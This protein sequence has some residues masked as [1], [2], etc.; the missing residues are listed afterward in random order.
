MA[1]QLSPVSSRLN[2]KG[3]GP[4]GVGE[5][6]GRVLLIAMQD[7][8]PIAAPEPGETGNGSTEGLSGWG[9]TYFLVADP[10]K[11]SPVWVSKNDISE[12]RVDG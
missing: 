3:V 4:S 7:T 12:H 8:D 11:P 5:F 2:V 9:S 6:A 10:D 1:F